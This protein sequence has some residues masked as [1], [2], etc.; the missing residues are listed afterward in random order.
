MKPFNCEQTNNEYW[1]RRYFKNLENCAYV[2]LTTT[3]LSRRLT[4]HLNDSRFIAFHL[5]NNSTP[6]S[7]FRKILVE[8]TTIIAQEINKLRLQTLEALHIE[9]KK[10]LKL[11]ELIFKKVLKWF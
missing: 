1:K 11:I 8:N 6:K 7:K 4:M 5:K 10:K 3:T 2:S 9:T